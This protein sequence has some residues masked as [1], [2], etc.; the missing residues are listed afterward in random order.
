MYHYFVNGLSLFLLCCVFF[1]NTLI[2][3]T[4]NSF[5][6]SLCNSAGFNLLLN[7]SPS[8]FSTINL[9]LP[10]LPTNLFKSTENFDYLFSS[11]PL[12]SKI[13]VSAPMEILLFFIIF[14]LYFYLAQN[15]KFCLSIS[16]NISLGVDFIVLC[17]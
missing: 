15:F 11:C 2:Y 16:L 4:L 7:F 5:N 8:E 13:L 9:L 1:N 17:T 10:S 14:L 3:F 12:D 6:N